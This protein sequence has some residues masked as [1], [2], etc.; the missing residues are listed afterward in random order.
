MNLGTSCRE[1]ALFQH[2]DHRDAEAFQSIRRSVDV[3]KVLV[4]AQPDQAGYHSELGLSWNYLGVLYDDARKNTEALSAF[5]QAVAEQQVAVTRQAGST[6]TEDSSPI[7][8]TTSVRSMSTWARL[9]GGCPTTV[10]PSRSVSTFSRRT[11]R[12]ASIFSISRGHSPHW[13]VHPAPCRRLDRRRGRSPRRGASWN[14][15]RPDARR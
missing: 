12:I 14:G 5:E 13:G 7:T 9:T 2:E 10:G 15:A 11:R 4:R 6:A 3:L 1:I 8:S